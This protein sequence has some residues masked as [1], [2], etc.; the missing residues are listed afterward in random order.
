[1]GLAPGLLVCGLSLACTPTV[2]P[3]AATATPD[4]FAVVRATSQA[5]YQAGQAALDRGDYLQACVELD[6]AKTNDPDNRPEIQQAFQ[7]ALARCLTPAPQRSAPPVAAQQRTIVV[8]TIA[9]GVGTA[10]TTT[11]AATPG[12]S[13]AAPLDSASTPITPPGPNQSGASGTQPDASLSGVST[14]AGTTAAAVGTGG[15]SNGT[16]PNGA[17]G[18]TP[19]G[20][21]AAASGGATTPGVNPGTSAATAVASLSASAITST[22]TGAA[23]STPLVTWSDPQG[24][25]SIGAPSDWTR[26]DQPRSLVGT[27]VVE[28]HDPTGRAELNV[29]VDTSGR[30][31]SPELYAAGLELAMQQQVPGYATE[32]VV[33]GTTAGNPSLRRVFSFTQRDATGQDHLARGFQLA[34]LK[35]ST[36]YLISGSAPAE[37]FQQFSPSFDQMVE[38]FRFS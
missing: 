15:S 24:R 35:G 32:Q 1:M 17:S 19:S 36:P 3:Q 31:V 25:F 34:I 10:S 30:A 18:T 29:A 5:A 26:T 23:A 20:P 14:N 6:Q 38:S 27:G 22:S 33:P 13:A 37:Q 4:A 2:L 11:K 8:A 7:Q 9:A 12:P 28:F 21:G 16:T